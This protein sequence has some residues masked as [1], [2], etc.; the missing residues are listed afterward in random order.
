M[1]TMKRSQ[2]KSLLAIG[3][4]ILLINL[5]LMSAT[6]P[7]GKVLPRSGNSRLNGTELLLETTL[8]SGDSIA[9]EAD[10]LALIEL[11]LGEQIHVGPASSATVMTV[12]G[13]LVVAL[14]S[15]IVRTKSGTIAVDAR[16]LMVRPTGAA[17]Y[18]VAIE[19]NAV[20]VRAHDGS[21]EVNGSN[22][23]F[24][25]PADKAMKFELAANTAPGS[26]GIGADNIT[27]G[28]GVVIALAVSLGV[29]LGV[30]VPVLLNEIDNA[31]R[32]ACIR[33]IQAVS[34]SAPTT[35]C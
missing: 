10:S 24:V 21:V 1:M 20:Y 6:A 8:F 31:E 7:L 12:E 28:Q 29:T 27:P 26:V 33:A 22:Q 35:G 2:L 25:V 3:V 18:D 23:S 15:G 9:T 4:S 5:P 34:P 19:N 17:T 14:Q 11:S 32:D 30:V 16:G 13:D